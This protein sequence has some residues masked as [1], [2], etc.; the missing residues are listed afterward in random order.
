MS[1]GQPL[2]EA[3]RISHIV[4]LLRAE[5]EHHHIL[6]F[7]LAFSRGF[8]NRTASP[9]RDRFASYYFPEVSTPT[10]FIFFT[11]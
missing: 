4:V 7:T 5:S 6:N 3:K 10:I 1:H 8:Q 11:F 2:G 9:L